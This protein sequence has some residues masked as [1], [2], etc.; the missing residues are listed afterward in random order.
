MMK[1][2]NHFGQEVGEAVN[3]WSPKNVPPRAHLQGNYCSLEPINI[4]KHAEILFKNLTDQN[5]GES[6]TYLPYGPFYKLN[7]FCE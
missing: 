6:W 1:I 4:Q 7:E 5:Q 3:N 2:I